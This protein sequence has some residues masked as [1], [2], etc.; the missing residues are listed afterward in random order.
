MIAEL[1]HWVKLKRMQRGR[2]RIADVF[3]RDI[4]AAKKNKVDWKKLNKIRDDEHFEL[5]FAD[6]EIGVFES[7]FLARQATRYRIP[8][9][10]DEGDWQESTPFGR[11]FL[12]RQGATKLRNSLRAERKAIWEYWQSRIA[13]IASVVGIVGGLL[14][15][16]AFFR[17][18]SVH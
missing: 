10:Q 9:P 5:S 4:A 14:G 3:D 11:R 12:S 8:V 7:D 16:A 13:L 1:I 17:T 15:A 18:P 2:A 6:D